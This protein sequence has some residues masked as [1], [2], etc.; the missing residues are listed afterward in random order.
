MA[1]RS[2]N[3]QASALMMWSL[4]RSEHKLEFAQLI[5][6]RLSHVDAEAIGGDSVKISKFWCPQHSP[7]LTHKLLRIFVAIRDI[8]NIRLSRLLRTYVVRS[9][10]SLRVHE[11]LIK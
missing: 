7:R 11:A 9:R 8:R 10:D 3:D 4:Q 6:M 2:P 1:R 5:T